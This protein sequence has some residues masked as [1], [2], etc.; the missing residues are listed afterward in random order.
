MDKDFHELP[1]NVRIQ[2]DSG[3]YDEY[4]F[5]Q[6][7]DKKMP[8]PI[9]VPFRKMAQKD[10]LLEKVLD[11]YLYRDIFTILHKK[12]IKEIV[13]I[14]K[15]PFKDPELLSKEILALQKK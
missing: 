1:K 13:K 7:N 5:L 12:D 3:N 10:S 2:M 14:D 9:F 6:N 11:F 15:T 4:G 8:L